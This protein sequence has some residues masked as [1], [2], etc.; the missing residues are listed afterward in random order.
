MT[1]AVASGKGGTG[2]TTVAANLARTLADDSHEVVFLD[3]DVE[4]PN[5]HIFLN[6]VWDNKSDVTVPIPQV[7]Q[8]AC[9][10][11]GKCGRIC[12]FSAIIDMGT[13]V[14]TFDDLCHSCGGC[15]LVCPVGAI[16]EIPKPIGVLSI[17]RS[18]NMPVIQGE[19][20]IGHPVSPPVVSAVKAADSSHGIRII[21]C[22]P[23][24]SCPV[25]ESVSGA[26]FVIL[27][28]EPTPFGLSDLRL[29]VDMLDLMKLKYG[30]VVNR[31]GIGDREVQ[32]FCRDKQIP[33]LMELADD[34]RIAEAY[35]RGEL[36]I[37]RFPELRSRF[38]DL[39]KEIIRRVR[40]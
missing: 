12:Q 3:C 23:G 37:D 22:P 16:T 7:D 26:D 21:D 39:Q 30:V 2:K 31:A 32:G 15:V 6:P 24:T 19:L 27:V 14:L 36:A 9:I 40:M 29:A 18:G 17:G 38:R 10:H 11:C 33:I 35:S 28:T 34:R 20:K 1:I 13:E 4:E 25:I 8:D 5:G